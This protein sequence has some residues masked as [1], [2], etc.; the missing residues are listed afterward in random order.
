MYQK[1]ITMTAWRRPAYTK[2]VIDNLKR[3]IGFEEYTILP[4]IEPGYPEILDS[5]KDLSNC[6]IIVNDTRLGCGA[7][8]LKALQRG[9]EISDFVIHIEDDTVPGIDSLRYLEWAKKTYENDK[10]IFTV[11]AYNRIRDINNIEPQNYFT[12]YRQKW[13][14]GWIW[15]TWIDRFEEMPRKWNFE[16]WDVN[17]NKKLR[18]KR[19]EICPSIP[20]S[21]NIGEYSGINV[22]PNFWRKYHYSPFW[23]NNILNPSNISSSD[24][25]ISSDFSDIISNNLNLIYTEVAEPANNL[26]LLEE[27]QLEIEKLMLIGI[28][29]GSTYL[30]FG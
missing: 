24:F 21:Q 26:I 23:I 3:C 16:S 30:L 17:I 12:S 29:I 1:V 25:Q 19:Y 2:Q 20:R 7:N 27:K 13:Y 10:E 5:F 18:G 14:T 6:N 9:F 4:T 28:L 11:T 8:T 22:R 15:G